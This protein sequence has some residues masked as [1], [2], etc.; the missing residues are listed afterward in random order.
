MPDV[1]YRFGRFVLDYG[2]RQLLLESDE[3]HLSPKAFE[4]LAILIDE[5][6]ARG[7]EGRAAGA[8]LAVDVRRGDQPGGAGCRDSTR[9]GRLRDAAGVSADGVSV[10]V[11]LCR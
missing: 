7:V 9:S 5:P 10:W 11:P 1:S 6:T 2:T 8:T 3:I 4:L